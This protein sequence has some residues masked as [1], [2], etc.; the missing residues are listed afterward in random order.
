MDTALPTTSLGPK[1]IFTGV[2]D[3]EAHLIAFHTQMMLTGGS[4]VVYCKLLMSTLAGAALEWFVSLPD[5]HIT[6]FDQFVTLFREKYL[7]N[8]APPQISYDVFDI[9][10]YQRESLKEFLNRFGVQVVRLKPTDEAMTVHAFTKGMLPGPF[11]E[12]LLKFYLK[13]FC[14]IRRRALAHIATED[15]VTEKRGFVGLIRTRVA[16]RPQPMW[17]HKSTIEKKD[18]G[19][20]RPYEKPQ[21]RAC[22]RGDPPPSTIFV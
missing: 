14:E 6:T 8:R 1:V 13:M 16:G 3:P 17:V 5:R 2:E 10:Q 21:T 12:S 18:K 9:K 4:D 15:R 11:S 7:I 20:Q 19:K 22:T